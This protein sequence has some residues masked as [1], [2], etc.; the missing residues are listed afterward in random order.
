MTRCQRFLTVI[1]LLGVGQ[2]NG[3]EFIGLGH[4]G[5][6]GTASQA[7]GVSADGSLVVGLSGDDAF[8]W[9]RDEGL[10]PLDDLPGGT[11]SRA[12]HASAD[13]SVVVG[14]TNA[15][16]FRWIDGGN[17]QG[18][19]FLPGFAQS[20]ALRT[21]ADG[22][23]VV[24]RSLGAAGPGQIVEPFRWTDS[25]GMA[26]LGRLNPA[27][28]FGEAT[29]VSADGSIVV[30]FSGTEAFRWSSSTGIQGL[31][32]LPGLNTGLFSSARDISADGN[33][34]VGQSSSPIVA[35]G[36]AFRWTEQ[37]GMVGLGN[38][39]GRL[40][41]SE[42]TGVSANG[43]RIVGIGQPTAG[44]Q[45]LP[46]VWDPL[47]GI[48]DLQQ[49]L[50]GQLGL[51]ASLS[52]W[53]LERAHAI[54]ADGRV[55]VGDGRNPENRLEAWV[56]FLDA[57]SEFL[58]PIE[59][60]LPG[61]NHT[62]E[63][64]AGHDH[65]FEN[66]QGVVFDRAN[67]TNTNFQFADVSSAR[68]RLAVMEDANLANADAGGADFSQAN[69]DGAHF[70]S[71]NF[72]DALFREAQLTGGNLSGANF[73]GADLT[74]A[75]LTLANLFAANMAGADLTS[76]DL[77]FSNL[78]GANFAGAV[79]AAADL[80]TAASISA[81]S[82]DMSTTYNGL[83]LFPAGFDPVAAGLSFV[84][85]LPG[86]T[87]GDGRVGIDDLNNVRNNFGTAGARVLGDTNG[88]R[89]VNIDDLNAVRNN[90]GA[91]AASAVPEP[92]SYALLI[93]A[94]GCTCW[95]SRRRLDRR[96]A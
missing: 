3:A 66:L 37:T 29:G 27:S 93:A 54:S 49:V 21:S 46:L 79:L 64:H 59:P 41:G 4:L 8:V 89:V 19:G 62:R 65:S 36:E 40:R 96:L 6:G 23:V 78:F 94:A 76:A 10:Q 42:A 26:A 86:D 39:G 70:N 17:V 13:G 72:V 95:R 2:A 55:I 60:V 73:R 69:L 71:G 58:P 31:G 12:R 38:M 43:A 91:V 22:K 32:F 47:D 82:F 67:L 85:V 34:I 80:S 24:G 9:T 35:A 1:V 77:S 74:S 20:E 68:F 33:T 63:T 51:G 15:Q 52:G 61:S 44:G 28:L 48:R 57:P 50:T 83:T 7:L 11:T 84:P 75:D 88:D 87:N 90:F 53:N 16:A 81:A 45:P 56:A 18:L 5:G 30:G 25:G 92:G 14:L